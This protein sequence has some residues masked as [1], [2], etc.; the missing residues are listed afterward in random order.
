MKRN[1]K[2]GN[3]V[4]SII[5][6]LY[7]PDDWQYCILSDDDPGDDAILFTAYRRKADAAYEFILITVE[8]STGEMR[9]VTT[10]PME[11]HGDPLELPN[12]TVA[13][14]QHVGMALSYVDE[15]DQWQTYVSGRALNHLCPDLAA[16]G[17]RN[18]HIRSVGS[19]PVSFNNLVLSHAQKEDALTVVQ[20]NHNSLE[21]ER[22]RSETVDDEERDWDHST[23][24]DD[25]WNVGSFPVWCCAEH[26]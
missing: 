23:R 20:Y 26:Y 15:E 4:Q 25:S 16:R 2:T 7:I 11:D 18:R 24:I 9:H 13:A 12:Q 21:W 5:A 22:L 6:P 17:A 10:L 8:R 19:F 1:W 3:V 14:F